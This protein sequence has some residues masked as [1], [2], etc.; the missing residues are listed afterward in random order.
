MLI[1]E[2]RLRQLEEREACLLRELGDLREQNELL[3][4][5]VL[6]LV[7]GVDKTSI[8]TMNAS[9]D[10][11]DSLQHI[12]SKEKSDA[13]T[14][15]PQDD[16]EQLQFLNNLND[17][18][19]RSRLVQLVNKSTDTEDQKCLLHV[20]LLLKGLEELRGH[21]EKNPFLNMTLNVDVDVDVDA[22][23]DADAVIATAT[24]KN[25]E[26]NTNTTPTTLTVSA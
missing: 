5:R 9:S 7:E 10:N 22:D 4:F 23:A 18:R 12:N 11:D 13:S 25:E 24:A 15:L 8:T 21:K 2:D 19:V 20:L 1:L 3:E 17:D 6:E 14:N 26:M 16:V